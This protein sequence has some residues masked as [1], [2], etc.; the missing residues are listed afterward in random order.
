MNIPR[1][2]PSG[3]IIKIAFDEFSQDVLDEQVTYNEKGERFVAKPV[4]VKMKKLPEEFSLTGEFLVTGADPWA[5]SI[6]QVIRDYG[7]TVVD[8]EEAC[9]GTPK[10]ILYVLETRTLEMFEVDDG[11]ADEQKAQALSEFA[12]DSKEVEHFV[13]FTPVKLE[14]VDTL[15]QDRKTLELPGQQVLIVLTEF[16]FRFS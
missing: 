6:A 4:P 15:L 9:T 16:S 11:E 1:D 14:A 5:E 12:G 3:D 8:S 2:V 13:F 10:G 7:G